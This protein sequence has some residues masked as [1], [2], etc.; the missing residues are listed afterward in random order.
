VRQANCNG[1]AK[2]PASTLDDRN[3][4]GGS[5]QNWGTVGW[6]LRWGQ[7]ALPRPAAFQDGR[8]PLLRK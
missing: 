5:P 6:V 3:V 7:G 2:E 8:Q 1:M 4:R